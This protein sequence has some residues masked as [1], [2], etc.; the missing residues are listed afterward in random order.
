M[1]AYRRGLFLAA[2]SLLGATV[3]GAWFAAGQLLRTRSAAIDEL[4]DSDRTAQLQDAVATH[5]GEQLQKTQRWKAKQLSTFA[6]LMRSIRNYG[7]H[8]RGVADDDV[9][10][11]F[12]EDTS[13]L[14]FLNVRAHLLELTALADHVST[15]DDKPAG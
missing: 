13:G 6:A 15:T 2:A 9:E 1:E 11:Y 12:E 5:I 4:V 7:V 3:E 10:A 14:L 8:P